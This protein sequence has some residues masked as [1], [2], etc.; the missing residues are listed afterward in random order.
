V[1]PAPQRDGFERLLQ[2][3]GPDRE[4]AGVRYETFRRK[5][6]RFFEWRGVRTPEE[7]ADETLDR[8]IR[9]LAEGE[10]IRSDDPGAY[11]HG[12]ARNVLREH[13]DREKRRK[14]EPLGDHEPADTTETRDDPAA[15]ER[16]LFCLERC[17]GRLPP[18]T[19]QIVLR[20]YTD[21]KRAKIDG[22]REMAEALGIGLNALRIRM[23][24]LRA[25]LDTCV[26]GC[27]GGETETRR[28]HEGEEGGA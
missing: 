24:R 2:V 10:E 9:R 21:E 1:T 23:F 20:Y 4:T 7:L 15:A 18:E 19:R 14:D 3:L 26:R 12:V 25:G 16:R 13:W 5:L 11:F 6:V 28:D 8:V 27:V 17:L 22:R